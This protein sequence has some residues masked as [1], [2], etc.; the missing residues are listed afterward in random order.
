MIVAKELKKYNDKVD[1]SR[2]AYFYE[3]LNYFFCL[4]IFKITKYMY[5]LLIYKTQQE[6]LLS[7]AKEQLFSF[8]ILFLNLEVTN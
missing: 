7:G 3:E 6:Q 4:F 1:C 2:S 5:F 8:Q